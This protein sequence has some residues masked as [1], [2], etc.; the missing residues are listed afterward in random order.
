MKGRLLLL[1]AFALMFSNIVSAEESQPPPAPIMESFICEWQ[2]GK[3][4]DDLMAARDNFVNKAEKGGYETPNAFIWTKYRG[5]PGANLLWHSI[6][7]N[8]SDWARVSDAGAGNE[9]LAAAMARFQSVANCTAILQTVRN[10][11]SQGDRPEGELFVAS[12]ACHMREGVDPVDMLDLENHARQYFGTLGDAA[13]LSTWV[14][15]PVTVEPEAPDGFMFSV[16]RSATHWNAF[17]EQLFGTEQGSL[18][19]RHF[20]TKAEC[21]FS[22][23]FSQ[24]AVANDA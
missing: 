16:F 24:V 6:Y 17:V 11:Y 1:S 2:P 9:A 8:L 7:D 14:S 4:M 5:A 23:W 20:N 3:D 12:N 15:N 13:P 18:Y 19:R 10:V 22:L 21:G